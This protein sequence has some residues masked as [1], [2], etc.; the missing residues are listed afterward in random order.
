MPIPRYNWVQELKKLVK[1]KTK[2]ENRGNLQ[3][4]KK[5]KK[6][7]LFQWKLKTDDKFFVKI[8]SFERESTRVTEQGRGRQGETES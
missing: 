8:Y 6:K 4:V 3:N 2:K 5:K 1:S 7:F